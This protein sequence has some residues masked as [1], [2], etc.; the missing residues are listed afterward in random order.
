MTDKGASY[1]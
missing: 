1:I